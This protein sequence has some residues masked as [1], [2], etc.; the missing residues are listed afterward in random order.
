M[1]VQKDGRGGGRQSR[2]ARGIGVRGRCRAG[3]NAIARIVHVRSRGE[4]GRGGGERGLGR[5]AWPLVNDACPTHQ[6]PHSATSAFA[7]MSETSED[8][9]PPSQSTHAERASSVHEARVEHHQPPLRPL[10]TLRLGGRLHL[11]HVGL[12]AGRARRPA[13]AR[14]S[15][16]SLRARDGRRWVPWA[17]RGRLWP[18]RG[19]MRAPWCVAN[20]DTAVSVCVANTVARVSGTAVFA[21]TGRHTAANTLSKT[22]L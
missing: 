16:V 15:L 12:G 3:C 6:T 11:H 20:T 9:H 19:Q 7:T 5:A 21:H 10:H 4:G 18:A 14:P 13:D 17:G 8:D 2:W 22:P 1:G